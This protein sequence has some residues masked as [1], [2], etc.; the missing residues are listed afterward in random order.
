M[1]QTLFCE[2][3]V[4]VGCCP[5]SGSTLLSIILDAQPT[6]L[7]GPELAFF[8]H[9]F[10]WLGQGRQWKDEI[11]DA[12]WNPCYCPEDWRR[13][14]RFVKAV[15][16]GNAGVS[17]LK[18]YGHDPDTLREMVR[19]ARSG[20]DFADKFFSGPL[21]RRNKSVWI[22]KTP[23][24]LYAIPAFLAAIPG[25]KGIV[26]VRDG[27]DV[28]SSLRRR[29]FVLMTAIA[30]WLTETMISVNLARD[31]RVLLVRYEDMVN[32]PVDTISTI[33]DF[34]GVRFVEEAVT[35]YTVATGRDFRYSRDRDMSWKNNP[36]D[37]I[38][39]SSVGTWRKEL[40]SCEL[41]LLLSATL[42]VSAD[43]AS[44]LSSANTKTGYEV[45]A[46]LGYE[47]APPRNCLSLDAFVRCLQDVGNLDAA[48]PNRRSDHIRR[49][50][51]S[52]SNCGWTKIFHKTLWAVLLASLQDAGYRNARI[53]AKAHSV[54]SPLR[55]GLSRIFTL[56]VGAFAPQT[57]ALKS[58]NCALGRLKSYRVLRA[59]CTRLK[60]WLIRYLR[61]RP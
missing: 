11:L 35:H 61:T 30:T 50:R 53:T 32:A 25:A 41:E 17:D 9:P 58:Q 15:F 40:E 14:N 20:P 42:S 34:I 24:N 60:S 36:F 47:V 4:L 2:N 54:L 13:H 12:L 19:E 10:V 18:W 8:S 29:G 1:G 38:S 56:A 46:D 5:S 37:G 22:E 49:I 27:R 33:C 16:A 59:L 31:P 44:I 7:C 55:F 3:P 48:L 57:P 43:F 21:R 6:L 45:L 28:V 39:T 51:L 23:P 26:M 52:L